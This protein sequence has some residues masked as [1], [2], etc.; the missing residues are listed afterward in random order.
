[1]PSS[2]LTAYVS[3]LRLSG[4]HVDEDPHRCVI[5][6]EIRARYAWVPEATLG[7]LEGLNEVVSPDEKA[8]L[9]TGS[10]FAEAS[11]AAFAWNEFEALSLQAA[12]ADDLLRFRIREFWN[13]HFPFLISVKSGYAYFAIERD[14]MSAVVGQEPEFEVTSVIAS[15][16]EDCLRLMASRDARLARWL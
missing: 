5:P 2:P 15:S 11:Q 13:G 1:M 16:F 7:L 3:R 10:D 14:S 9:L 4:W 8:W 12:G 6:A